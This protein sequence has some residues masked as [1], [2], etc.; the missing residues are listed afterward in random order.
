[1]TVSSSA[2]I[3]P[4]HAERKGEYLDQLMTRSKKGKS[5]TVLHSGFHAVGFGF[6]VLDSRFSDSET[7]IPDSNHQWDSGSFELYFPGIQI[8]ID[9]AKQQSASLMVCL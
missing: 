9:G 5:K 2:V 7:W 8:P 3:K 6:Q 4:P 1:M